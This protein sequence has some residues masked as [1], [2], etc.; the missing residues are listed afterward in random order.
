MRQAILAALLAVAVTLGSGCGSR[1]TKG[2]INGISYE[3]AGGRGQSVEVINNNIKLTSGSNTIEIKEGRISL[4]GKDRGPIKS[5]DYFV[6]DVG[7]I[8]LVQDWKCRSLNFS[9]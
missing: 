1:I 9:Q 2:S 3:I 8:L 4:N 6:L 5:G 7:S